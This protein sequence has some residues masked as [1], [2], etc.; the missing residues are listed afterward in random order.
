[1]KQSYLSPC[2]KCGAIAYGMTATAGSWIQCSVCGFKIE[3]ERSYT[4]ACHR[5]ND[6]QKKGDEPCTSTNEESRT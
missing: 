3:P 1:M 5:W 6:Q 2:P 4:V